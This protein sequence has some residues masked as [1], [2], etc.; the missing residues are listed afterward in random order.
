MGQKLRKVQLLVKISLVQ[1]PI[2]PKQPTRYLQTV[3]ETTGF[4]FLEF[5]AQKHFQ[6]S[7]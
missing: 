3:F 4:I 7:S 1:S 5:V 6:R 2:L